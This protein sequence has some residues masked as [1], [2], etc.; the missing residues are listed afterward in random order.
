MKFRHR[1]ILSCFATILLSFAARV[2]AA[3][4][5]AALGSRLGCKVVS[6]DRD[7]D[8]E[9]RSL[10]IQ[11]KPGS[12]LQA[13]SS[14]P[15]LE[16]LTVWGP[17]SDADVLA[18]SRCR[19]LRG[20]HISEAGR[21]SDVGAAA[22]GSLS[23]LE[24]LWL[25]EV[26]ITGKGADGIAGLKKLRR[27]NLSGS[28]FGDD[29]LERLSSFPVLED[30]DLSCTKITDAGLDVIKTW[31]ALR[32]LDLSG[33]AIDGSGFDALARLGN[34]EALSLCT[35]KLTDE[36]LARLAPLRNLLSLQLQENA[37]LHDAGLATL[38]HLPFLRFLELSGTGIT[39]AGLAS[40][41]PLAFAR[42]VNLERTAVDDAAFE[43]LLRLPKLRYVNFDEAR[44]S[45]EGLQGFA[46]RSTSLQQLLP[47]RIG[48]NSSAPPSVRN[49]PISRRWDVAARA[50]SFPSTHISIRIA[51]N[52]SA[53]P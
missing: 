47:H 22:L 38:A 40:L 31:P 11:V 33:N 2:S 26:S 20:L 53:A 13:L 24:D 16:A 27:L 43:T 10:T 44:V 34:L 8:G 36:G 17:A 12:D 42:R 41:G 5:T 37:D 35:C 28:G 14:L 18:I 51:R 9:V 1:A 49:S 21:V 32:E 45:F 23:E 30:V 3:D 15:R 50:R 19:Q 29:E 48:P 25:H 46:R 6:A 52:P 7:R 4:N 39:S